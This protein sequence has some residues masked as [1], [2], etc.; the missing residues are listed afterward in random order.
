[1]KKLKT[2]IV[3]PAYNA[4]Q[5][6]QKTV[7]AIPE[8]YADEIILVDDKSKDNTVKLAKKI[9]LKVFVHKKNFG[10]GGNQKT[11]YEQALKA[12]ADIVVMVHPDYQYAP[13]L[14]APLVEMIK[15]GKY[16]C[17]LGSRILSGDSVQNGMPVYKY[18]FNRI[19][20]FI[21]NIFTGAK[22]S[23]Y[24]TGLRAYNKKLL[25]SISFKNNSD[26][27]I[28]DNQ[29][30]LQIM[31]KRFKI[32]EISCPTKYFPQA[33]SIN[34]VRSTIYG[35]GCLYWGFLYFLGR[36]NIYRHPLL[37]S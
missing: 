31:A 5:T 22:L 16:D 26:D 14:V 11:C 12:G 4:E 2:V 32:G 24:H 27:F 17:V 29:I 6:L 37:F 23:E 25:N 28:F 21:E 18:V 34:F 15:T 9:K 3:L 10:Y 8:N 35:F 1:M 20:T 13:E 19:L 30:L 7:D 36:Y 33:S